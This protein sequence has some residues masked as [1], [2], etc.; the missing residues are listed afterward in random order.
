MKVEMGCQVR[1]VIS[2]MTGVV[3]AITKFITG[4][5]HACVRA[6]G[7]DKDGKPHEGQWFDITRLDVISEPTPEIRRMMEASAPKS[8]GVAK[9]GADFDLPA[10]R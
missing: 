1:E 8:E 4:C 7:V 9:P 10:T 2:G 3:V 5:D 6:E